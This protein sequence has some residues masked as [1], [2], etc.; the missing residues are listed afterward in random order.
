MSTSLSLNQVLPTWYREFSTLFRSGAGHC[1]ILNGDVHGTALYQNKSHLWFMQGLLHTETRDIV[2][3]YHRAIGITFPFPSTMAAALEILGP[4]WTPP[5]TDGD[6]FSA[7]LDASGIVS[8]GTSEPG[9]VFSSARRPREAFVVLEALLRSPLARGRVAIII[10]GADLICPATSKANMAEDRLALLATFLYWGNDSSLERQ[11]NPVFLLTPRLAELHPDLRSV[12]SGYKV[13]ELSLPDE[14][15]RLS[16][17]TWYLQVQRKDDPIPLLDLS[18]EDLARNTAGLNLRQVEDILLLGAD[19]EEGEG[20]GPHTPIGVTRLLVKSRKDAIIRQQYSETIVMLDPLPEGFGGLGGMNQLID[21]TRTEV[22]AP[23]REGRLSEVPKGILLVGPPGNGKTLYVE[24]AARELGYNAMSLHMAK[25]LG[26]IV[27]TS[28]RNLRE[29]FDI[30]RSNAPTL[31]F[32][33]EIDQT[34]LS[35]RG[36]Q[37]GSPVAANLFGALLQFMGDE[38][39]RGRVIVVGAT[40]R[41]ELLDAALLRPGRFDVI[42]PVLC[43][44]ETAR[45]SM[46]EVQARRLSAS[47]DVDAVTLIAHETERYSAADLEAVVKEGRLLARLAGHRSILLQDAREALENI[48]PITLSSVDTFTRRALDACNNLRFLPGDIAVQERERR[49]A[50]ALRHTEAQEASRAP[51]PLS[52]ARLPRRV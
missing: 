6:P 19:S 51:F 42:F 9:D 39:L 48:R 32:I 34:H 28:E 49:R 38:S 23:L 43:P 11:N 46:L 37:S 15:T 47:I 10:D 52:E 22:I 29:L 2:V 13:I 16:Y 27:G 7:A 14:I 26:G 20:G 21:W 36:N 30:A 1:F 24:A 12:D 40:N 41:P 33:D 35:Q 50:A 25:V 3:Y 4:N 44:D 5:P 45:R 17:I 8:A 31:L 18:L